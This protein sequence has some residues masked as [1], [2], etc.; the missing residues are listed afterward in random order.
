[1]KKCKLII[2]CAIFI[3]AIGLSYYNSI[4]QALKLR[5]KESVLYTTVKTK[6]C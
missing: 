5:E 1:M 3:V 2:A 6:K 4:T